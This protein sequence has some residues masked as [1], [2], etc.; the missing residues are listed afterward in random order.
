MNTFRNIILAL[1][2]LAPLAV[3]SKDRADLP[4]I[5]PVTK[6]DKKM[7]KSLDEKYT[8]KSAVKMEVVKILKQNLLGRESKS[9]GNITLSRGK[10]RLN[11]LKPD[12]STVIVD[13]S[14]M[15]IVNYPPE[16]FEGASL[17]VIQ[18][19]LN[20]GKGKSQGLIK[21]LVKG[22]LFKHFKAVGSIKE[23][24]YRT[25]FL[26]PNKT[27]NEFKRAQVSINKK[28]NKILRLRYW[29]DLDNETIYEFSKIKFVDKVSKDTF[30]FT[31]PADA[32]I[33]VY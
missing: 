8:R 1:L 26:Q 14:N 18:A 29:D 13:K 32:D 25:F 30:S 11:F 7:L 4:K 9:S 10:L 23:K 6:K 19:K 2:L 3:F 12:R 21:M 20:S 17:Q 15:W 28:G 27:T 24:G 22:G 33:T 5:A 31:P 16:E